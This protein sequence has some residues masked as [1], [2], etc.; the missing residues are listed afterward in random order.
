MTIS[1]V[2]PCPCPFHDT[3]LASLTLICLFASTV[4]YAKFWLTLI[5]PNS[6][7][8]QLQRREFAKAMGCDEHLYPI[9]ESQS[10]IYSGTSAPEKLELTCLC[11]SFCDS[12]P[13]RSSWAWGGRRL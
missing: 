4:S 8:I 1:E 3:S 6:D 2:R 12:R 7:D 10:S 13:H 5:A 11:C 9:L